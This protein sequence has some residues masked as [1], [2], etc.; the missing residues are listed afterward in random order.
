M[1]ETV[2]IDGTFER[3]PTGH[4]SGRIRYSRLVEN[5]GSDAARVPFQDGV[6][7]KLILTGDNRQLL[8]M[9]LGDWDESKR[10]WLTASGWFRRSE[11]GHE[12]GRILVQDLA[13]RPI[14]QLNCEL[15][16]DGKEGYR[17]TTYTLERERSADQ[18]KGA[19]T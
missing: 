6:E 5:A 17:L 19:R 1:A 13:D 12:T 14:A 16:G 4:H 2:V 9:P 11:D 15:V 7:C 18:V 8:Q 10:G 3:D